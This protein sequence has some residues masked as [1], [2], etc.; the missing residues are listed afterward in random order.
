MKNLGLM[1]TIIGTLLLMGCSNPLVHTIIKTNEKL[2]LEQS[3]YRYVQS[4][5]ETT[6]TSYTL[7]PTG[8]ESETIAKHSEVLL[9]DIYGG[10]M[11]ECGFDKSDLV[12]V[13]K[14][15]HES[16][17]FYEV[18]TFNDP[19]SERNDKRSSMS[20]ILTAYP[21]DGGTDI[22]FVGNCHAKPSRIVFAN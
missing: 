14:V 16:L 1:V 9:A 7:E 20:V 3:P 22:S 17:L 11:S 13:N 19:L 12:S 8:V 2:E 10:F 5:Q 15:K 4:E 21:N 6:H 18:W